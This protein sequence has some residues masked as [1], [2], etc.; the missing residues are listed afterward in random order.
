[1]DEFDV[2]AMMVGYLACALWTATDDDGAPLDKRFT[3]DDFAVSA[4]GDA[5]DDC[6]DFAKA[7]EALLASI[8]DRRMPA[9]IGHDFNLTRNGHG[10]GFWDRGLGKAG[11]ELTAA[12]RP[13]GS[14][15]V[16]VGDDGFLHFG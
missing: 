7:N 16:Y 6:F 10:T 5:Y 3:T 15:D 12:C 14:A 1:M 8:A 2:C 13:Y 9:Y 4:R 11:D